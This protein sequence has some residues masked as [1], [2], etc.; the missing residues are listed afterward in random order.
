MR[1]S[2][3]SGKEVINMGDGARLGIIGEC[4]L[5]F[6]GLTGEIDAVLLPMR[7]GFMSFLGESKVSAIPWKS[8]RKIGNDV[9]IIDLNYPN[10]QANKRLLHH[11]NDTY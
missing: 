3:L 1:L 5:T 8:I 11:F 6:N 7:Q 2:E 10:Q 9:I 4:E